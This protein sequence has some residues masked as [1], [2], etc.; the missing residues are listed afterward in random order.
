MWSI[1]V[2]NN[3]GKDQIIDGLILRL[4][5]KDN[6]FPEYFVRV[7]QKSGSFKQLT[8]VCAGSTKF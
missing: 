6:R 8:D 5:I 2:Y 7:A 1:N 4:A 3:L